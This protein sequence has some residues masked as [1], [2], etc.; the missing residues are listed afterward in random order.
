MPKPV[1]IVLSVQERQALERILKSPTAQARLVFRAHLI[2]ACARDKSNPAVAKILK[3]MVETVRLWRNRYAAHGLEG[4][5]DR[6]GRGRKPTVRVQR[7]PEILAITLKPPPGGITHWS[8]R[9]LARQ[10]GVSH[11]TV[12]KV[13]QEHGLQPHR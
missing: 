13:W 6:P 11:T 9:R 7:A 10:V 1:P 2:L 4:L 5:K 8:T 12:H 3:C